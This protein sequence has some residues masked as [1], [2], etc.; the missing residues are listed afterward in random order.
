MMRSD[1]LQKTYIKYP[2]SSDDRVKVKRTYTRRYRN[3]ITMTIVSYHH[4][5]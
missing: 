3:A 1:E 2:C 5:I 4:D